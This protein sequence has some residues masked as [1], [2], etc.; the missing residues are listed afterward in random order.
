MRKTTLIGCGAVLAAMLGGCLKHRESITVADDGSVTV[1]VSAEGD[2]ADLAEGWPVPL[3]GSWKPGG[4]DTAAWIAAVGAVTGGADAAAKAA[5]LGWTGDDGKPRRDIRLE[6]AARFADV[7]ALPRLLAPGSEPYATASLERSASFSV[8]DRGGRQVHRFRRTYHRRAGDLRALSARMSKDLDEL[9]KKLEKKEQLTP[10]EREA[11]TVRVGAFV[12][13]T[14]ATFAREAVGALYA[15]GDASLALAARERILAATAA[16]VAPLA[17]P[18]RIA[19]LVA[20]AER[21]ALAESGPEAKDGGDL[22]AG[23][24]RDL[25]AALR[26][27]LATALDREELNAGMRNGVLARLEWLFAREDHTDDLGDESFEVRVT[28]PG[29]VV[30]GNFSALE[31][32]TA[33][34][35]FEGKALVDRDVVLEA[36]SVRE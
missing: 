9:G 15:D 28:L 24:E 13:E 1:T 30:S 33:I 3:S 7:S 4:G 34:W 8:E 10:G 19:P 26:V 17:G 5:A 22:F 14:A 25:R 32:A 20:E 23:T 2:A 11:A 29:A 35:T 6:S 21:L 31:G 36:V 18:A 27:A 12:R 16:A